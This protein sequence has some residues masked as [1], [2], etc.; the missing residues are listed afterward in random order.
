MLKPA[1]LC[2]LVG[3]TVRF[4]AAAQASR[5]IELPH[6]MS[7]YEKSGRDTDRVAA[8]LALAYYYKAKPGE[9]KRD[10]DSAFFWTDEAESLAGKLNFAAGIE[11]AV[12]MR[13]CIRIEA[14]DRPAVERALGALSDTN[15]IKVLLE[16]A[17]SDIFNIREVHDTSGLE[18]VGAHIR[19]CVQ[20]SDSLHIPR[21]QQLSRAILGLYYLQEKDTITGRR[22]L[23]DALDFLDATGAYP[24]EARQCYMAFMM[25]NDV[26]PVSQYYLIKAGDLYLKGGALSSAYSAYKAAEIFQFYHGDIG[27]ALAS[28]RVALGLAQQ[29]EDK[30][31]ID[32]AYGELAKYA[33]YEGDYRQAL[34]YSLEQL[35]LKRA[36]GDTLSGPIMYSFLGDIYRQLGMKEK[37]YSA[38]R[39]S[40][41]IFNR[42]GEVAQEAAV[43]AKFT[44]EM[45]AD[46]RPTEALGLLQEIGARLPESQVMGQVLLKDGYGNCYNA[47]GQYEKARQSLLDA[48]ADDA[49]VNHVFL[50][51]ACYFLSVFYAGRNQPEKAV[52]YAKM[53]VEAIH[54]PVPVWMK[55]DLYYILYKE[56][57]V[58]GDFRSAIGYYGR[59]ALL[60]DTLLVMSSRQVERLE[61]QVEIDRRDQDLLAKDNQ[62]R[63]AAIIRRFSIGGI[64]L[65]MV[66]LVLLY[67]QYRLKRKA[68]D[69]AGRNNRL[70]QQHL[71]EKETMMTEIH[72]R[73]KNNLQ[74]VVSLL[75]S[76]SVY[77]QD[78]AL[79]AIRDSQSRIHAMS[80]IHQKLYLSSGNLT[81]IEMSAY[82]REL[83]NDLKQ[84]FDAGR[85]LFSLDLSTV[86]LDVSQ[87]VPIGLITNEAV[88]NSMKHAF[89]G[90]SDAAIDVRMCESSPGIFFLKIS[91]NGIG[92]PPNLDIP[93]AGSLGLQLI[94]GLADSLEGSLQIYSDRGTLDHRGSEGWL[95][96]RLAGNLKTARPG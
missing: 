84:A 29:L 9:E 52:E 13:N 27:L 77:L 54:K 15:R 83:I 18:L 12:F 79:S 68:N 11:R 63:Q 48:W 1:L 19:G 87:A 8:A 7:A 66:I 38:Y 85:I 78:G 55:K 46:G 74:T 47:L 76:Q 34:A 57:S 25:L 44:W 20:K 81:K 17:I 45:I 30:P 37:S 82:M 42:S 71:V 10:M 90:Q 28:A 58:M 62:I 53:A 21:M 24:D 16:L 51:S 4:G 35:S 67:N 49:K 61:H 80:L 22:Y 36:A 70:L 6:L 59:Y 43:A 95:M 93:K 5:P 31:G 60:N 88:T 94:Q 39:T 56:D 96:G 23:T 40:L 73:V 65:L 2:F 14:G 32:E 50:P 75:E 41:R 72:H 3:L 26:S 89:T 86:W 91:D 92:L 64:L 69:V 33:F